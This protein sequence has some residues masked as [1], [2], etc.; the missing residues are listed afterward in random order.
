MDNGLWRRVDGYLEAQ[1][2]EEDEA[3]R[4]AL[5]SSREAGLPPINVTALQG[6][7]LY[8]LARLVGARRVLE[9]GALGGYSAIWLG[10]A[11]PPEGKLLSLELEARH[12]EV[13]RA[14]VERAGLA[15]RIEV[16]VGRAL[17]LLPQVAEEAGDAS[18]DL[19]FIDADKSNNA[20]YFAWAMR[21]VR[22]GGAVV[23][24][25]VVR[26]GRVA[27]EAC[28]DPDVIGTRRLFEAMKA[29][30]GVS[31]TALQVVGEKGYDGL[32]LAIV[33]QA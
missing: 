29:A 30:P 6:K 28:D 20:A 11:L 26:E 24:D 5:R 33:G 1:L 31:A 12:A 9:I 10:R 14:N 4:E 18:F 15:E 13:A 2:A 17:E 3:L 16:R 8:V 25:N 21:L 22:P 7:F 32:A 23:V 27:D 19:A